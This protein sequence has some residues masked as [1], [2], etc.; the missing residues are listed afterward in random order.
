MQASGKKGVR[1]KYVDV[2]NPGGKTVG[3]ASTQ[4]PPPA[5]APPPMMS[6]SGVP[7]SFFIPQQ[8]SLP[9]QFLF[10]DVATE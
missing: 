10:P 1:S 7:P 9:G 8:P 6:G 5:M 3:G 2:M 4:A